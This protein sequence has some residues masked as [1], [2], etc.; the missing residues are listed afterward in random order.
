MTLY[1][2]FQGQ[3]SGNIR[4]SSYT[5][6][7]AVVLDVV[8]LNIMA[9]VVVVESFRHHKKFI[10]MCYLLGKVD[11]SLRYQLG[12]G[13]QTKVL[14]VLSYM[15]S[16]SVASLVQEFYFEYEGRNSFVFYIPVFSLYCV[17]A[18]LFVQFT[19]MTQG[20]AARF[21]LI[22]DVI[23]KTVISKSFGQLFRNQSFVKISA[24]QVIYPPN[25]VADDN[26]CLSNLRE[27]IDLYWLLCDAVQYANVFYGNQL[28]TTVF[29]GFAHIIITFYYLF[30]HLVPGQGS[31]LVIQGF[32]AITHISHLVL[33]VRPSTALTDA[34]NETAPIVCRLINR[35]LNSNVKKQLK[36]FLLQLIHHNAALSAR[37]VFPIHSHI[38][39][40]IAGSVTTYLVILIQFQTTP[41]T[42]GKV[43]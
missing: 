7:F 17:E 10:E 9:L 31:Y 12:Y 16:L 33:L 25:H 14:L 4:M 3:L 28:L 41:P 8:S 30:L 36:E 42:P 1:V 27:L 43:E 13:D 26:S 24:I 38:L 23:K 21:R 37:G 22:N 35:D 39:T 11:H 15:I 18:A 34:A 19:T 40:S 20:I 5:A 29:S 2:D 32:W 6:T